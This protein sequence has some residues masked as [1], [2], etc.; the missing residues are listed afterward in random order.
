MKK[1][2]YNVMSNVKCNSCGKKIKQNIIDR[3]PEA[4]HCYKCGR[5]NNQTSTAREVRNHPELKRRQLHYGK[6]T[7]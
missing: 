3:N 5:D 2:P 4:K 1:H 6:N 7:N